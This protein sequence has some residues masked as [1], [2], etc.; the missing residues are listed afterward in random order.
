MPVNDAS[1]ILRTVSF[2]SHQKNPQKTK[3][4]N[5]FDVRVFMI[6]MD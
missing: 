5:I 2:L 3:Q 4:K 1:T 6:C